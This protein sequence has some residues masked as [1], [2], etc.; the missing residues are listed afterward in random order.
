LTRLENITTLVYGKEW[1]P[2][3]TKFSSETIVYQMAVVV[4]QANVVRA[5]YHSY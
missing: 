1:Y 3:L 5:V 4:T 2:Q